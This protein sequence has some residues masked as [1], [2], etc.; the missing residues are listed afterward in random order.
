MKQLERLDREL[1]TGR[2][3]FT[4]IVSNLRTLRL[5]TP[6]VRE[7][8]DRLGILQFEDFDADEADRQLGSL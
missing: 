5:L 4:R 7:S 8:F 2:M 3:C 1:E 6:P